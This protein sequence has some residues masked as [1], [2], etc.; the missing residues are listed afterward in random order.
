[1]YPRE[2][3]RHPVPSGPSGIAAGAGVTRHEADVGGIRMRWDEYG[4]GIPVV[5][6][7]GIPTSPRLWRYVMPRIHGARVI[8]WEMVGFGD[9][10]PERHGRDISVRAQAGHLLDWMRS[11]GIDRAVF[12]GHDLGGGVVQI[13]ALREPE[14]CLGLLLTNAIGYDSWPVPSVKALR[15][16][17][18]LTRHMPDAIAKTGVFGMLM[19][20]GH[21]NEATAEES[22]ELHWAPYE[23]H[24]AADALLD[25]IDA[26][27]VDDTLAIA[28]RVPTLAGVPSRVIWGMAD[29]FQ[30]PEY[31]ERFARDLGVVLEP[32]D[33]GKHFT[34][35]DHPDRIAAT[36][37][38]LVAE[39]ALRGGH[40]GAP[41][42]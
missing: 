6:V 30:K 7:H 36:L 10:I 14:R 20:R 4:D 27:D 9:S 39:V 15:A 8:A 23:Q 26:L 17:E 34:P 31:G 25:Q 11:Q 32:I 19:A 41:L 2:P 5:L 13:A 29:S 40:A 24:G 38:S 37:N 1:M 42:H 21:D 33:G 35:E 16:S 18:A 12:G 3:Q 28:D 22:L